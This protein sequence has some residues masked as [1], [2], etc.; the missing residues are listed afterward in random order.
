MTAKQFLNR[1]RRI[2]REIS[3]LLELQQHT[4]DRLTNITQTLNADVISGSHDPHK[5][6]KLAELESDINM[7]ID[8]LVEVKREIFITLMKVQTRNVRLAMIG[9]Y[10]DMKTW[11][12]IAVDM[13]YSYENIMKLRRRGLIEVE[14]L[15]N[16]QTEKST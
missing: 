12:Q 15:I 5:F 3:Q 1:A 16:S 13:N 11:E 7:K 8:E 6:D 14:L 2:D 9:Y 4:R 10:L